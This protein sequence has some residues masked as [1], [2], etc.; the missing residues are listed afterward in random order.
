MVYGYILRKLS[1]EYTETLY[2]I[3]KLLMSLKLPQNKK[4]K[5]KTERKKKLAERIIY[6]NGAKNLA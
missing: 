2:T 3:L 1:D 4:S 6:D 5:G